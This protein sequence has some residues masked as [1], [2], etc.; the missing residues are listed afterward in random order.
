[1]KL[2]DLYLHNFS[3]LSCQLLATD[4]DKERL[5][6]IAIALNYMFLQSNTPYFC[7]EVYEA[8]KTIELKMMETVDNELL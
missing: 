4:F 6:K 1:M 5:D 2:Y 8:N 7:A 3:E